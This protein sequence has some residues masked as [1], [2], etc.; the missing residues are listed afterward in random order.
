MTDNEAAAVDRVSTDIELLPLAGSQ[1]LLPVFH[2]GLKCS[3]NL[4]SPENQNHLN[5]LINLRKA[6]IIPSS[7]LTMEP[8][9][10]VVSIVGIIG[11]A[12]TAL[13]AINDLREFCR[14]FSQDAVKDFLHDLE[15]TAKVL[16]DVQTLSEKAKRASPTLH[17]EYRAEALSIQVD[18]CAR[19]LT[20][21][22]KIALRMK[23]V[24]SKVNLTL[25]LQFFNSVLAAISKSSRV[26]AGEKLRWHRENIN[27]TLS[28]FGM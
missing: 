12:R 6:D 2:T 22:L 4:E 20:N 11:F 17:I 28:L 19:D 18:D 3:A 15:V 8:V 26:S 21:W 5:N 1:L 10:A 7:L 24:R 27:T 13:R 16:T 9:S 23:L 14:D 25:R